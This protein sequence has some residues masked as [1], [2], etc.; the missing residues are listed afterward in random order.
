ML[1]ELYDNEEHQHSF[2]AAPIGAGIHIRWNTEFPGYLVYRVQLA[3]NISGGSGL[4][5]A[6][7]PK[8]PS[9]TT[10]LEPQLNEKAVREALMWGPLKLIAKNVGFIIYVDH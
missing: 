5:K 9:S 7:T 10:K 3:A 1:K 4:F 6:L 2:V 8:Q